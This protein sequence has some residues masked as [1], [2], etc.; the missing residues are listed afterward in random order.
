MMMSCVP[1]NRGAVFLVTFTLR[2][3]KKRSTPNVQLAMFIGQIHQPAI[4][5]RR[6]GCFLCVVRLA[7]NIN[8]LKE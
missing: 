8:T 6:A 4:A 3:I 7:L 5:V 2:A 1:G